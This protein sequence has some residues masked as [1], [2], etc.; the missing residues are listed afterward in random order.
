MDSTRSTYVYGAHVQANGIRQHYLRFGG[1]GPALVV[2]P[3]ITSPAATWAFVGERLGL[4]HDTY[5]LDVRGRG[6]SSAGSHLDYGLDACADDVAAFAAALGLARYDLLGHSMGGRIA[7]RC[8]HR[9]GAGIARLILADPPVSGPGRRPYVQPLSFYTDA[10]VAALAGAFDVDA[11]HRNYPTWSKAQI[12]TRGEWLHT[13]AL[14]AVAASHRGFQE[15]D[16]HRDLAALRM[17]TLLLAAGRGGVIEDTDIAE[18]RMLN[19]SIRHTR[20]DGAGHMLP[21]DDLDGFLA[22]VEGFLAGA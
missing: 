13:C 16:I 12:R 3:G 15:D 10:I 18:I 14:A 4:R 22:I 6:L 8:A 9:H 17:P 7:S 5:V 20:Q 11:M 21:F 2:V 19:P 1:D